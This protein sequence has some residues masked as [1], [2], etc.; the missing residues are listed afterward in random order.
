MPG[1]SSL[2][3]LQHI[4]RGLLRMSRLA[5]CSPF[6]KSSR[7][8]YLRASHALD[9]YPRTPGLERVSASE[10]VS[11]DI[12]IALQRTHTERWQVSVTELATIASLAKD[13][14][15]NRIFE[16]GTFDGRTTLNLHLNRPQAQIHTIDFPPDQHTLPD[17][18]TAGELVTDEASSDGGVTKL[19]GN[20]LTYDFGPYLGQQDFVFIDA[21][22]SYRNAKADTTTALRMLEGNEGVVLWHDY[23]TWPGVTRAVEETPATVA[24]NASFHWIADTT[25]AVMI[26]APDQPLR[27]KPQAADS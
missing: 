21:G 8:A 16:F 6:D 1:P 2:N 26:T 22:H 10:L 5:V 7:W 18:K 23:A 4:G 9:V 24:S 19:H 3:N 14:G 20:T 27:L 13:R 15:A 11:P 12:E 25:L 17:G